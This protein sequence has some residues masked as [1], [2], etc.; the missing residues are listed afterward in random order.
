M[1]GV[2]DENSDNDSD[3]SLESNSHAN[4]DQD[5]QN[6]PYQFGIKI[7]KIGSQN[8]GDYN[9]KFSSST[10]VRRQEVSKIIEANENSEE[11]SSSSEN[12][13]KNFRNDSSLFSTPNKSSRHPLSHLQKRS[14]RLIT[15]SS[16]ENDIENSVEYKSPK[17]CKK[18]KN[19][20][21]EEETK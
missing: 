9:R 5:Y 18:L 6:E 4:E 16:S 14:P 1:S 17:K 8:G 10:I 13:H 11:D 20:I 3:V 19:C 21:N 7:T 2:S 12:G 15:I